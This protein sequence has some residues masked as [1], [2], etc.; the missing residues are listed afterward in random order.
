MSLGFKSSAFLRVE[1]ALAQKFEVQMRRFWLLNFLGL[2]IKW[3]SISEHQIFLGFRGSAWLPRLS[4]AQCWS[5]NVNG[6]P[7]STDYV[8]VDFCDFTLLLVWVLFA[9]LWEVVCQ[10]AEYVKLL[11][12]YWQSG[13][14]H[15]AHAV[16][17][18]ASGLS[19]D[20]WTRTSLARLAVGGLARLE[21]LDIF[22]EVFL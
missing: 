3:L 4:Y 7:S 15:T 22:F 18:S 14:L 10:V 20:S 1:D 2:H 16:R 12:V 19:N 8:A 13:H 11:S 5:A 9:L 17:G 6:L 21:F